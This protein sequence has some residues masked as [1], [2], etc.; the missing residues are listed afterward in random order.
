MATERPKFDL[1]S[2]EERR[3]TEDELYD[4]A[5]DVYR[6]WHAVLGRHRDIIDFDLREGPESGES[7]TSKMIIGSPNPKERSMHVTVLGRLLE[8][9]K[10]HTPRNPERSH[11]L[12][13]GNA[14]VEASYWYAKK[15]AGYKIDTFEY[16]EMTQT[17][18][19]EYFPESLLETL[20]KR[21]LAHAGELTGSSDPATMEK[22]REANSLSR[23]GATNLFRE[24]A[25]QAARR[26]RHF[27]GLYFDTDFDVEPADANEYWWVWANTDPNTGRF[28]LRQNFSEERHKIWTVGKTEELGWHEGYHQARMARR[29]EL[30]RRG[31]LHPFFGLTTVHGPE[32]AV[33]EGL[34]QTLVYF[35]PGAYESLSP[36]G[37]LRVDESVLRSM[38]YG[39]IHLRINDPRENLS[40]SQVVKDIRKYIP[41][42]PKKIIEEEVKDRTTDPLLQTYRY[43]YALGVRMML[44]YAD[45]L[46]DRGKREFLKN[47]FERPYTLPQ[48]NSLYN[49]LLTNKKYTAPNVRKEQIPDADGENVQ[50]NSFLTQNIA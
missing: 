8:Q 40:S 9:F 12:Q 38:V 36:E 29:R 37:R 35:V 26:V 47:I 42:E 27:T 10:K 3:L 32:A 6:I 49:R 31:K 45:N 2:P 19:P 28:L 11:N 7:L 34:G 44:L 5:L 33:D 17:F 13:F 41:W 46:N 50:D 48:V 18:E 39:N 30:I 24:K 22:W 14:Q 20:S 15:Q 43:A 23:E 1:F 16:I 4:N 21:L 25:A